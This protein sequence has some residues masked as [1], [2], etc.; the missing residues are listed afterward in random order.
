MPADLVASVGNAALR[1]PQQQ[2]SRINRAGGQHDQPG[3]QH[4]PLAA[5]FAFDAFNTFAVGR[6]DQALDFNSC[7]ESDV[8]MGE[9]GSKTACLSIRFSRPC[10]TKRVRVRSS[11]L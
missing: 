5:N 6:Y 10:I 11:A 9:S 4:V 2:R 7:L 3:L 1:G 8:W